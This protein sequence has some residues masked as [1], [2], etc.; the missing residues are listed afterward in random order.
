MLYCRKNVNYWTK[1]VNNN[2]FLK[3][4]ERNTHIKQKTWNT[5]QF[6]KLCKIKKEMKGQDRK[7]ER[8]TMKDDNF[9]IQYCS[10]I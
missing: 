6:K 5:S 3:I 7:I 8:R 1:L 9:R 2:K 4:H 10:K